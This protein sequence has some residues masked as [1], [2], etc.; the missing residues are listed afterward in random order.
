M[1]VMDF[2]IYPEHGFLNTQFGIKLTN[3]DHSEKYR[4][5]F[6][7]GSRTEWLNTNVI[8][9]KQ[10]FRPGVQSITLETE[11]RQISRAVNVLDSIKCGNGKTEQI[12]FADNHDIIFQKKTTGLVV[13]YKSLNNTIE[14]QFKP[15]EILNWNEDNCIFIRK[16][17]STEQFSDSIIGIFNYEAAR[18]LKEFR[19]RYI[20]FNDK[21]RYFIYFNKDS[22]FIHYADGEFNC[23]PGEFIQINTNRDNLFFKRDEQL[24]QYNIDSQ[25]VFLI[26]AYK[27]VDCTVC[28]DL[29]IIEQNDK[30]YLWNITSKEFAYTAIVG[31]YEVLVDGT[32]LQY[33]D[34]ENVFNCTINS[35]QENR[36]ISISE[37]FNNFLS[38]DKLYLI[39]QSSHNYIRV[40]STVEVGSGFIF[41][42]FNY[43]KTLLKDLV[44]VK[45]SED[46][47]RI[48]CLSTKK[49][50][51]KGNNYEFE[52]FLYEG[53]YY[54]VVNDDENSTIFQ[55][56]SYLRIIKKFKG[57]F[58]PE[59]IKNLLQNGH[60]WIQ[61]NNNCFT[62]YMG[63]TSEKVI[64]FEVKK[65]F[66]DWVF[67]SC[68]S[69]IHL[70]SFEKIGAQ[71]S[72]YYS[73]ASDLESGIVLLDDGYYLVSI[74][75]SEFKKKIFDE[76]LVYKSCDIH[77]TGKIAVLSTSTITEFLDL[78]SYSKIHVPDYSFVRFDE[79]GY[80]LLKPIMH[81]NSTPRIFD[82]KTL[83]E[84]TSQE[85]HLYKFYSPDGRYKSNI[86]L[87]R[88][89]IE[90]VVPNRYV[91]ENGVK[92]QQVVKRIEKW[93]SIWDEYKK[94][95]L[96]TIVYE[97]TKWFNFLSFSYDNK[98]FA[99]AGN[100]SGGI[101][102]LFEIDN[103]SINKIALLRQMNANWKCIF[104]SNNKFLAC[105]DSNPIT[106]IYSL[107]RPT[108]E[109]LKVSACKLNNRSIE[110]FS[111][112][113]V[114][115]VLSQHRYEAIS[116]GG[117][118]WIP[119]SKIFINDVET[120]REVLALDEHNKQVV[121]ANF[122]LDGKKLISR[123]EDGIVIV[124]NFDYDKLIERR[125]NKVSH[126]YEIIDSVIE[127]LA[128]ED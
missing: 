15:D 67:T 105:Y 68:N 36:N 32:I 48:L 78:E 12:L 127:N 125:L 64:N 31:S 60:L 97:N 56:T 71:Y 57:R 17:N 118:G 49:I 18:V 29:I 45:D 120:K 3:N 19:G 42:G 89:E 22:I 35:Y 30:D 37:T 86:G 2:D 110:C 6:S 117:I 7:D 99:V 26:G 8:L 101:L 123:S 62:I 72:D 1:L 73:V 88:R 119:S 77:P 76:D 70:D 80:I 20:G 102:E 90:D 61:T 10:F 114:F 21:H 11:K 107:E 34:E 52:S 41:M 104:S 79:T 69:F 33:R 40:Y 5:I 81:N 82:P 106:Y 47:F 103:D 46:L 126:N 63:L 59:Y 83:H 38:E 100:N 54:I 55:Y 44:V 108:E 128:A 24:W 4:F 50:L 84:I 9:Y 75:N 96:S 27:F 66:G 109:E 28:N 53:N 58:K 43:V 87:Q 112:D 98:Y 115:M 14:L 25:E 51:L 122:S 124:R 113:S 94:K 23:L 116:T 93:I 111:P 74:K 85:F 95:A 39:R 92:K 91:I 65:Y 13:Y 121:F 16:T